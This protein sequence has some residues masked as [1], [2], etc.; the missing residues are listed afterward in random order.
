MITDQTVEVCERQMT[1]EEY[2][3]QLFRDHDA[4]F[5]YRALIREVDQL[6]EENAELKNILDKIRSVK[7]KQ[8]PV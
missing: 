3:G 2:V 1:L 6:R 4:A 5:E 7:E 8:C